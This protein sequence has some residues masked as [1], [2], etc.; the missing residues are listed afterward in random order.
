LASLEE[1]LKSRL[2][3][4]E[5]VITDVLQRIMQLLDPAPEPAPVTPD[6]EM[7]FH[8]TLAKP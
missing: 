8:T 3:T 4:H 5:V 2:D 7:G 6:K 1:E